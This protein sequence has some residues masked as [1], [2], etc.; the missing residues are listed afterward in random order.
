MHVIMFYN[1]RADYYQN[2]RPVQ[3]IM[4]VA[5]YAQT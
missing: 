1:E 3:V 2:M 4:Y 5:A